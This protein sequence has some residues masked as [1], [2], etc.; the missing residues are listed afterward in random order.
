[1]VCC[2]LFDISWL[3]VAGLWLLVIGHF[4]LIV[5]CCIAL[6][7]SIAIFKV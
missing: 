3:L 2:L 5:G 1:M 7:V 4:C 6:V